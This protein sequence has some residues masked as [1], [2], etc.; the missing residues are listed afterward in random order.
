MRCRKGALID[1]KMK[2]SHK[3]HYRPWP[4]T[5]WIKNDG[6]IAVDFVGRF[7]NL[8]A[9]FQ[10]ICEALG[11]NPVPKLP[12]FNPGE[13]RPYQEYYD[14]ETRAIVADVYADDIETFG[15]T[16]D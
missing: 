6:K 10:V 7:E 12:H 11:I 9:D 8:D 16:F 4:Q 5:K 15:Y 13:H 1:N 14:D 3:A 2:K